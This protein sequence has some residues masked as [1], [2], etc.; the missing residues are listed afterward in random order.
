METSQEGATENVL[1]SARVVISLPLSIRTKPFDAGA[2]RLMLASIF[3]A[4]IV[5]FGPVTL[6]PF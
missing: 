6:I 2:D 3:L 5:A 1:S 4:N